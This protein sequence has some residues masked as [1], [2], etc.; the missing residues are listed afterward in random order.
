MR[1]RRRTCAFSGGREKLDYVHKYN[2]SNELPSLT[3][4]PYNTTAQVYPR[5][6]VVLGDLLA[7]DETLE[8]ALSRIKTSSV[9]THSVISD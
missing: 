6:W 9:K 3:R 8:E 1:R 2:I 4:D 7:L 5:C